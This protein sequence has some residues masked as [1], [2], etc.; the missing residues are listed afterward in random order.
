MLLEGWPRRG[1]RLELAYASGASRVL[2]LARRGTGAILRLV[3]V[4][5]ARADRFQPLQPLDITPE[6]L[7]L[8]IRALKRWGFALVG[9]DEICRRAVE[10]AQ[11]DRTVCLTFDGGDRSVI[12][13]GYPV[14]S[15]HRVP[16]ALYIPTAFPDGV[17][18]AWWLALEQIV[19]RHE[20]IALIMEGRQQHF[21]AASPAAKTELFG[22]LARWLMSLPRAESSAAINDL[23]RRYSVDLAALSRASAMSW[24]DLLTL[25]ADPLVTFGA[26]TVNYPRLTRL[27]DADAR[28]ELTMGRAVL[29]AALGREV[30]H[31]AFPFGDRDSVGAHHGVMAADAGFVSAATCVPGLIR[32]DG[33]TDLHALPRIVWHGGMPRRALHALLAGVTLP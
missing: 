28:R 26:A 6:R 10:P 16:F 5:P 2:G 27:A 14:L 30:A 31:T 24:D 8:T 22:V 23:C 32:P 4:Q 11:R 13:H 20:R 33:A 9:L 1:L 18:E 17:G 29:Q 21:I 7:D 3:R 25:A 19:A 12:A 15:Q